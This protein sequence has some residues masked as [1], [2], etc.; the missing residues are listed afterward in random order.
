MY[1]NIHDNPFV[2][3]DS[4]KSGHYCMYPES[5]D[6]AVAYI[7]ARKPFLLNKSPSRATK[8]R[9]GLIRR[10]EFNESVIVHYGSEFVEQFLLRVD[11]AT[12]DQLSEARDFYKTHGLG[13]NEYPF[14]YELFLKAKAEEGTFFPIEVSG[15]PDGMHVPYR[16]PQIQLKAKPG[17]GKLITW[18]ES[19]ILQI[20][21]Y[22][23]TVAT[24]SYQCKSLI[25][26]YFDATV[27]PG[28]MFLLDSRLHDFG[29]R[30]VSS[31][32]SA[33]I[34]GSAHLLNFDGS[35]TV[36]AC[37]YTG[38]GT[39]IPATEHSVMTAHESELDAVMRMVEL[40]GH[41]VFATVADSYDYVNFLE[42][43]L[44][45][46]APLVAAKGGTHIIR[47]DSGDPVDSVLLGLE[48]AERA[49]GST[50]NSKGYKVLNNSGVIQGDGINIFT[51]ESILD[52]VTAAGYSASNVAFGMGGA[53]LQS[54]N[55]DTLSYA[56]KLSEI[57]GN[58]V[59]K[60]PLTDTGKYSL[61]GAMG[62]LLGDNGHVLV[63]PEEELKNL[64]PKFIVNYLMII[65][66]FYFNE[67]WHLTPS[68]AKALA[69]AR[70][71]HS[72]PMNADPLETNLAPMKQK[73]SEN[74]TRI[75]GS[76]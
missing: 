60:A 72:I 34:G 62:V 38:T 7:E 44:P 19:S 24:L 18:L 56:M 59:M 45:Q 42:K 2:L 66:V 54:V 57:N 17:Y 9:N 8:F 28:S 11:N 47:P 41:T 10:Y 53:L 75:R 36:P 32:E 30:G 40:F 27:D 63:Y 14:P 33:I 73:I 48:Y 31:T 39:S 26:H 67:S 3:T 74:I 43:I 46:V 21:W 76:L 20:V 23:S 52:A 71:L 25:R 4:Y 61:P 70:K 16:T 12:Y 13:G 49:Y 64:D 15:L 5:M 1:K 58:P 55:R 37:F 50:L 51:I 69:N 65:G 29:Y 68:F 35:D 22:A 6:T